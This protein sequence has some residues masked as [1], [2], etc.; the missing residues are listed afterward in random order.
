MYEIQNAPDNYVNPT[1]L[2]G[3]NVP[4]TLSSGN[5][6][7]VARIAYDDAPINVGDSPNSIDKLAQRNLQISPGDNPGSAATNVIPQNFVLRPSP[8]VWPTPDTPTP[9]PDVLMIDWGDTPVGSN[10]SIYWPQIAASSVI[11]LAAQYAP[12]LRVVAVDANTVQF[13]VAAGIQYLPIPTLA[14]TSVP[15]LLVVNLPDTV[16]VNQEFTVV[17]RSASTTSVTLPVLIKPPPPPPQPPQPQA[18]EE[19]GQQ[20]RE[21]QQEQQ[22]KRKKRPALQQKTPIVTQPG[23]GPGS[24]VLQKSVS[25]AF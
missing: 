9:G 1:G 22:P 8:S 16:V 25:G 6:C 15:G 7:L 19:T 10:A 18:G 20:E 24:V 14:A 23:P 3:I 17:I 13:H 11:S 21:Q 4:Q 2:S 12:S 5:H